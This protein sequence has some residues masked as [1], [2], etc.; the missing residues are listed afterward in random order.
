M[1]WDAAIMKEDFLEFRAPSVVTKNIAADVA[2]SSLKRV[3]ALN[4]V[5]VIPGHDG[6][7]SPR[8]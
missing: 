4:P 5:M 6:P 7:F 8:G 1:H 3:A 2:I